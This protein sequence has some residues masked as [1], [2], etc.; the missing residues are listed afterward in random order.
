[1]LQRSPRSPLP[2]TMCSI[3]VGLDIAVERRQSSF[4]SR[5]STP[6]A[7]ADML[8]PCMIG[9]PTCCA[10]SVAK[11]WC[12]MV[13]QA[14]LQELH[15]RGHTACFFFKIPLAAERNREKPMSQ[16]SRLGRLFRSAS[17]RRV[18]MTAAWISGQSC[19]MVLG[20]SCRH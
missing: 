10:G 19:R 17:G 13:Q 9:L 4:A 2:L 7:L 1:M 11:V 14:L 3:Q 18:M 8:P 5:T 20:G 15:G 6:A 16:P 12:W